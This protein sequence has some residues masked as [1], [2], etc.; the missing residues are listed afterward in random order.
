MSPNCGPRSTPSGS[1]RSAAPICRTCC[2][3]TRKICSTARL[4]PKRFLDTRGYNLI[5]DGGPADPL[6]GYR[7]AG[8]VDVRLLLDACEALHF[9][10]A[11]RYGFEALPARARACAFRCGRRCC[12]SVRPRCPSCSP[13]STRS[14][15][16]C[17]RPCRPIGASRC[18]VTR[19]W[20]NDRGCLNACW[21]AGAELPGE[22]LHSNRCELN[23]ARARS[24]K[25]CPRE[26]GDGH[27]FS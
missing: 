8:Q 10:L 2:C 1:P 3:P 23:T 25:A 27:R 20:R 22:C 6:L 16:K 19:H 11:A 14:S 5:D 13:T 7:V 9:G 26:G 15:L 12:L 24:G 17:R 21:L 4:Q 18:R